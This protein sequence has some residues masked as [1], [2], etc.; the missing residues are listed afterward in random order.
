MVPLTDP[1]VS[2]IASAVLSK[3]NVS[4]ANVEFADRYRKVS[5]FHVTNGFGFNAFVYMCRLNLD[6]DG[7]PKTYGLAARGSN[8]TAAKS[9]GQ[10]AQEKSCSDNVTAL[11]KVTCRSFACS[12]VDQNW[13]TMAAIAVSNS[14][15]HAAR[16]CI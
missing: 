15:T 6:I 1:L 9:A 5:A 14:E 8:Q 4:R 10:N 3:L 11:R 2:V 13:A 12:N 16:P 7:A